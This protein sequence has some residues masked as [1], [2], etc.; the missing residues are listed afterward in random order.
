MLFLKVNGKQPGAVIEGAS[1]VSVQLEAVAAGELEKVELVVDGLVLKTLT[2][3]DPQ[4][5]SA[6]M[7]IG[8]RAGGWLAARCF[9]KS[10]AT[11]RFAHTSPVYFG[12]APRRSPEALDYLRA[13]IAADMK[14]IAELTAISNAQREELL[15]LCCL[16]YSAYQ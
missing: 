9:E 11:I 7:S 14:R 13:W 8:V 2:P 15:A 10:P 16:A 6:S 5:L 3:S 4:R 1:Q 12:R